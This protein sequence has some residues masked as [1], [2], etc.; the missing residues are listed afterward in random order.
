M[1]LIK[2]LLI[3]REDIKVFIIIRDYGILDLL[4][5]FF[6]KIEIV[7][8]SYSCKNQVNSNSIPIVY[9]KNSCKI[10]II[11]QTNYNLNQIILFTLKNIFNCNIKNTKNFNYNILIITPES[12]NIKTLKYLIDSLIPSYFEIVSI[13]S[14]KSNYEIK[15]IFCSKKSV[16]NILFIVTDVIDSLLI[17][18]VHN[19]FYVIDTCKFTKHFINYSTNTKTCK[20]V[21]CD[22]YTIDRRASLID[23]INKTSIKIC[24]RLI[25]YE[26]FLNIKCFTKNNDKAISP[27]YLGKDL[28]ENYILKLKCFCFI[29]LRE[30]ETLTNR[31][32]NVFNLREA[33]KKLFIYNIIDTNGDIQK[34]FI[35]IYSK[36]INLDSKLIHLIIK[37]NNK[38]SKFKCTMEAVNLVSL[39]TI[40]LNRIFIYDNSCDYFN[41]K[42]RTVKIQSLNLDNKNIK[43]NKQIM[44]KNMYKKEDSDHLI[45]LDIFLKYKYSRNKNTII[46]EYKLNKINIE[47]ALLISNYIEYIIKNDLNVVLQLKRSIE[48]DYSDLINVLTQ[49]YILNIAIREVDGSYYSIYNNNLKLK[50][51]SSSCL[52]DISPPYIVYS[53]IIYSKNENNINY[54]YVNEVSS[55][56]KDL[57]LDVGCNLYENKLKKDIIDNY[58]KYINNNPINNDDFTNKGKEYIENTKK[59]LNC[60]NKNTLNYSTTQNNYILKISNTIPEYNKKFF[61]ISDY[62]EDCSAYLNSNS[63]II[64]KSAYKSNSLLTN[65]RPFITND[66]ANS[67][68]IITKKQDDLTIITNNLVKDKLL[69]K[70]QKSNTSKKNLCNLDW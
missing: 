10:K 56:S 24:F 61:E 43:M 48:G 51:H 58:N 67:D 18:N 2:K 46:N 4:V 57:I 12:E 66:T 22:N 35:D 19:L 14:S 54:Y 7:E 5:N 21:L 50:I 9:I 23:T 45:I 29:N 49:S 17:S 28:L 20:V 15:N 64:T 38:N 63:N 39:L 13:D 62:K 11:N 60:Q 42:L 27:F 33:F 31:T 70:D 53:N 40:G 8:I 52:Y 59:E 1:G 69:V 36:F 6:K 34:D 37:A 44:I 55:I 26:D 65:K 25:T 68:D 47:K 16:N 30:F 3:N 32:I 41:N